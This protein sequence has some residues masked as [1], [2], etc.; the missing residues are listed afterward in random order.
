MSRDEDETPRARHLSS[1]MSVWGNVQAWKAMRAGRFA[2]L[3]VGDSAIIVTAGD[4]AS[5]PVS[6][7]VRDGEDPS[8][9]LM[10]AISRVG[11][12]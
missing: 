5:E 6:E 12:G 4:G 11:I 3:D 9:A 7:V 2:H 10:R 8:T 1:R